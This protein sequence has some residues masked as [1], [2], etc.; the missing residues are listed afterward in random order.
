MNE[1][2]QALLGEDG[3]TVYQRVRQELAAGNEKVAAAASVGAALFALHATAWAERES[4]AAGRTVTAP[5]YYNSVVI[6]AKGEVREGALNALRAGVDLND[7]VPVV[8]ISAALPQKKLSNKDVLNFIRGLVKQQNT[9]LSADGQAVFSILPKDVRHITYSSNKRATASERKVREASIFSI[10]SL[11][12]NAVLIESIPNRKTA[13]KP[14]VRAYHRFYVP[15]QA[16]GKMR[17]VRLVA[18]EQNGAVTLNPTDVNLYDVI[19]EK[20]PLAP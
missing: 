12:E 10:D 16:N 18:E 1:Q 14:N 8:D 9:A 19:I 17:T 3:A 15:V 2:L 7:M 11:L 20:R 6:D 4:R 5:D 13:K